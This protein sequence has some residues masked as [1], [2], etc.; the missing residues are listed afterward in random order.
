MSNGNSN[1]FDMTSKQSSGALSTDDIFSLMDLYFNRK[2]IMYSHM[3]NSFNKFIDDDIKTFLKENDNTFF[4]HIGQTDKTKNYLIKYKFEFDDIAIRPPMMQDGRPMYPADA[5]N[6]NLTYAARL[7]ATVTQ[8]Q[9]M[10]DLYTRELISRKIVGDAEKNVPIANIPI[11]IRSKYCSLVLNK[12]IDERECD[13]DPGCYFINNGSEKVIISQERMIENKPLVFKKKGSGSGTVAYYAQVNS[14]SP[15]LKS[16]QQIMRVH[17][18]TNGSI[19]LLVPILKE[20]PIII[21]FRAMGIKSDSDIIDYIV[22]DKNDHVMIDLVKKAIRYATDSTGHVIREKDEAINYLTSQI[23]VLRKYSETDK[24]VRQKQKVKHLETLLTNNFM[25]HITGGPTYKVYYLGYVIN[26]LLKCSLGRQPL[27]DRDSCINKRIELPGPLMDILFRQFFKKM[28]NECK[29]YWGSRTPSDEKPVNIINQIRP[30]IIE[31][32]LKAAL[33]TGV[34]SGGKKGVAQVLQRLTYLQAIEFFRRIDSPSNDASSSKLTSP[35]H[36]HQTQNAMYCCVV[37][38]TEVLLSDGMTRKK[39]KDFTN[40]DT[41]LTINPNTLEEEISQIHSFFKKEPESILKIVTISG[42]EIKC[43]KDHQILVNTSNGNIWKRADQITMNDVI[44]VMNVQKLLPIEKQIDVTVKS[45]NLS[46]QYKMELL[47]TTLLDRKIS[48]QKLEITARLLGACVTDG[49]IG[50]RQNQKYYDCEFC[51][52][53]EADAFKILNDIVK[54]GFGTSSI[55]QRETV[56]QCK[57]NGKKTIYNTYNVTKNGAFAYYLAYMGGFVGKKTAMCR[58]VPDWIVNGN[59][60]IKQEFLSGFQGGDGCRLSVWI[61]NTTAKIRLSQTIQTTNEEFKNDTF[62]YMKTISNLFIEF[63]ILNHVTIEKRDDVYIVYINFDQAIENLEKYCDI[64]GY[65]YCAEKQRKSTPVIEYLKYKRFIMSNKQEKYEHIVKLYKQ[66]NTPQKIVDVTGCKYYVVKRIIENYNKN[67]IPNAK[68]TN[69]TMYSEYTQ[70]YY[71]INDKML[72]PIRDICEV[73]NESVYDFTTVSNNHSFIAN[74]IVVHNCV[75]TPEHAKVGL[76]KHLTLLG[77]ITVPTQSQIHIIKK[78]LDKKVT[79]LDN[80]HPSQISNDTRVFLNG[81]M[82]GVVS[83]PIALYAELKTAKYNNSIES[84]CCIVYDDLVNELRIYCDGGRLFR[85]VIRVIDNELLL[86]KKHIE[87][88]SPN[89]TRSET[90]VTS[91]DEFMNRYPGVVE[92]IDTEEQAYSLVSPTVDGVYL[93]HDKME[94]SAEISAKYKPSIVVNRYGNMMFYKYSHSEFHPSLLLGLITTNIPFCNHNQGP[95]NI[96]QYAQGRQAMCIYV[97]NYRFR[98]DTSYI[99][100]HPHKPLVNTRTGKYM[101]NDILS[102]GENAVVAIMCYTGQ[103]Q[104]DSII[105]NKSA[106]DRGLFRSTSFEKYI[107]TLQK[108]KS[109]SQDEQFMKPDPT[110]VAGMRHGSYEKLNDRGFIPEETPIG[111]GDVLVGKVSPIQPTE[112]SNKIFKDNSETYKQHV[113]GVV[114]K[115]FSDIYNSE[116]YEM[117]KIRTRSERIPN[118]GDKLCCYEENHEILTTDGWIKIKDVTVNHKVACLIDGTK[119]EYH[120][121]TEIQSYD[122]VGNMYVLKSNQVQLMVTPNHRMYI[123]NRTHDKYKVLQAQDIYHKRLCYMKNVDEFIPDMT[124]CP[125]ELEVVNGIVK[126]FVVNNMKLPINEWLTVFGIWIAEGSCTNR[127]V[128]NFAA[129]KKRVQI[130]LS[131]C[132]KKMNLQITKRSGHYDEDPNELS[133]WTICNKSIAPYLEKLSVGAVNKYLPNWVW[134][135]NREQCRVLINGMMLGD[136]HTMKNGTRRYDTSS[137]TLANDFQ[138]LCLHAG[139]STNMLIKYPPGHVSICKKIGREGEV[140]KS[141]TNSYRLTIIETQN[142]PLVNKNITLRGEN[143]CDSYIPF[144]GKVYCCTVPNDGVIYIRRNG[145]PVWCGNSRHG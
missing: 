96:F 112:N 139:W 85:P 53:E 86:T 107:S 104:E 22:Q 29:K 26:K 30:N 5:R 19:T 138:R 115:V 80:V 81:D 40:A 127:W 78:L 89:K 106:I 44:I 137:Y 90:M 135:L 98:M 10:V 131:E 145:I 23:R 42:H 77:S 49:H 94:K 58:T 140:F 143:A 113:P 57:K 97:S 15:K 102:P 108:N 34:W 117:K 111:H 99:L 95:R 4:E 50:I 64:I 109:T 74:G 69:I 55:R 122:Y 18:N 46:D 120:N 123:S 41:I 105:V 60:R 13:Y 144:N 38:D 129:N 16:I 75:E 32:G 71:M 82:Y 84:T 68:C 124:N 134:Y 101:Y 62:E 8:Y 43:T 39:I 52:G 103:N 37:G 20:F 54:L 1:Q 79:K 45:T 9:E 73:D 142:R 136:G 27:D 28:L 100:Y 70:K 110:K 72:S 93:M 31:Q 47:E 24:D 130:A 133:A 92:Y 63:G 35:R 114:D 76:V 25:P 66:N 3:Y 118:V 91:W 121:P 2:N 125:S 141:T 12:H 83:K 116:Q 61:E 33:G 51:V 126:Q 21:L 67:F 17:F 88:I 128:V 14:V 65:R 6:G 132:C 7:E 87:S 119:L 56:H 36:L 59:S 48:Q 11:M